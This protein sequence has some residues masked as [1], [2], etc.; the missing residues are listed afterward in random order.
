MCRAVSRKDGGE[1]KVW[2]GTSSRGAAGTGGI[3]ISDRPLW[4]Q[5]SGDRGVGGQDGH[6][7]RQRLGLPWLGGTMKDRG[8]QGSG[9]L[10][11]SIPA[12]HL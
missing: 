9:V 8:G 5:L 12:A 11:P 1:G 4:S 7:E 10:D 3:Q 2:L 6:R